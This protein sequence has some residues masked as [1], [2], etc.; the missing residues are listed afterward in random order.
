MTKPTDDQAARALRMFGCG[1]DAEDLAQLLAN[2]EEKI[3]RLEKLILTERQQVSEIEVAA[4][5]W[6]AAR[7]A[8][9]VALRRGANSDTITSGSP[10]DKAVERLDNAVVELCRVVREALEQ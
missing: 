2:N 9:S 6:V 8:V 5:G 4:L 7:D 10:A 3:E 1:F